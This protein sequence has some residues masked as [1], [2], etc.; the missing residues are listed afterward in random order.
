MIEIGVGLVIGL[1]LG[2]TGAGGSVIAVPLLLIATPLT[3]GE[4]M[5][6]ALG[7]VAVT[8]FY[9]TVTQN[10]GKHL[11][12]VLWAPAII[13]ATAG[14]LTAPLGKWAA[15]LVPENL[16]ILGFTLIAVII[17]AR[18]WLQ[19]NTTP[20]ETTHVRAL[21]DNDTTQAP[22]TMSCRLSPTGQF[23]LKFRCVSGLAVGGLGIGLASGLFGVGGGFLIIP[24]LLF[25]SQI[26]MRT[27][28]ATSLAII[29]VVSSSGF[30]S[31]IFIAFQSN[32]IFDWLTFTKLTA[33]SLFAMYFSQKISRYIAGPQLQKI[34]AGSLIA[35]SI[36]TLFK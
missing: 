14:G 29:T 16:L 26:P 34:F 32:L 27:A 17:G 2:L 4:A 31:Y 3:A 23:Q 15:T 36:V 25:L 13:L 20:E 10:T 19:A 1:V 33:A 11:N 28:V 5:G 21:P 7:T 9:A 22:A 18:M 6:M 30:V 8:A 12:Q 35:L 24:L